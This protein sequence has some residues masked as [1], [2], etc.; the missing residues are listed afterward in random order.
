MGDDHLGADEDQH[1]RKAVLEEAELP[2]HARQ[3]EEQRPE[4]H[5]REHVGREHDERVVGNRQNRGDRVH[6]EDEVGDLHR[7]QHQEQR[8]HEQDAVTPG[9]ELRTLVLLGHP[10]GAAQPFDD[11][12]VA[13]IG[14]VPVRGH[15]LVAG[16]EQNDAE[17]HADPEELV[18]QLHARHDQRQSHDDGAH[19]AVEEHAILRFRRHLEVGE[20]QSD[21][22]DVVE[23]KRLL[24]EIT[25]QEFGTALRPLEVE[26]T[27]REQHR[28]R[29]I[30]A[31]GEQ[32]F[33][34]GDDV[35]L[36]VQDEQVEE[37][38]QG[39]ERQESGPEPL[40]VKHV[41]GV[42]VALRGRVVDRSDITG[43]A[44]PARGARPG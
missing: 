28:Q 20:D 40:M 1:Q 3:H 33:A 22:E 25:R 16:D 2:H 27:G 15:H 32:G 14:H 21:H 9:Q 5:D 37:K 35:V 24:D 7:H 41:F 44:S 4:T 19:D 38:D 39:D 18:D 13:G 10:T 6:R 17:D 8:R 23:R 34:G 31:D 11:P 43:D 12:A 42:S 30:A 29:D 26:D 36:A